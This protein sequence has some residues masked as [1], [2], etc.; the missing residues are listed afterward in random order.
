MKQPQNDYI[1]VYITAGNS[2]EA[3]RIARRLLEERLAACVN[4]ISGVDSKFWWKDR[5]EEARETALIV[6]TKAVLLPDIIEAVK[7]LHSYE[8]PEIIALPIIGGSREYL[9]WID[10]VVR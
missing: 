4:T 7:K 6:K 8:L 9:E 1:V 5:L 2:E 3:G 10:S